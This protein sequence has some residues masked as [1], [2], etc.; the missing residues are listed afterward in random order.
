MPCILLRMHNS[1]AEYG[2]YRVFNDLNCSL[3]FTKNQ[4][5]VLVWWR[6][7]HT[8]LQLF[9][10]PALLKLPC[11]FPARLIEQI[12]VVSQVTKE[13]VYVRGVF[14]LMSQLFRFAR[15]N[16][17]KTPKYVPLMFLRR[18]RYYMPIFKCKYI[19]N[20]TLFAELDI[21]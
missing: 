2:K 12:D 8:L 11:R 4:F 1:T 6:L 19:S 7:Q 17:N 15:D 16:K 14:R 18:N 3:F 20:F 10:F 21:Y 9:H 5:A 13:Y